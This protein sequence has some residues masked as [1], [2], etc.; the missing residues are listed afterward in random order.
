MTEKEAKTKWC[1]FTGGAKDSDLRGRTC[2]GKECLAW[3]W[4]PNQYTPE[5]RST[6]NGYC[7][8]AGKP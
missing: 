2:L 6:E 3:R 8:L 4:M 7:G 5:I 1:P